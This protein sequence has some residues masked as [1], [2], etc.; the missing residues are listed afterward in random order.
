VSQLKS[1]ALALCAVLSVETSGPSLFSDSVT[2]VLLR[3]MM[4]GVSAAGPGDW[5][6]YR[7]DAGGGRVSF[8]RFSVVGT[9]KDSFGRDSL[10]IEIELGQDRDLRAPLVQIR[11][12]VVRDTGLSNEGIARLFVALGAD[13]PHEVS[14]EQLG[15]ILQSVPNPPARSIATGGETIRSRPETRLMTQAG[16]LPAVPIEIYQEGSLLQRIWMSYRLPLL[17]LAKLEMPAIGH[18]MEVIG[19][20]TDAQ[21]RMVL[22]DP[23]ELKA[24]PES[25]LRSTAP[26]R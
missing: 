7:A 8:W 12:L 9:E 22:P 2:H 6:S 18:V 24:R 3:H 15:R 20:G 14:P 10:W 16:I 23:G 21:P 5:V 4:R 19:F 1:W 13:K 26:A 11:L 17:H 25:K